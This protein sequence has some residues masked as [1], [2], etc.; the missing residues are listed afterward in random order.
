MASTVSYI[1]TNMRLVAPSKKVAEKNPERFATV[2][3]TFHDAES[4]KL[5]ITSKN[6]DRED[7][8]SDDFAVSVENGTLTMPE[9]RR[10]RKA[11]ESLTDSAIADALELLRNP[12]PE[13]EAEAEPTPEPTPSKSK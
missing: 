9:G 5:S 12:E 3:G 10:G 1:I 2:H 11:A 7:A 4:N 6:I 8:L 13:V